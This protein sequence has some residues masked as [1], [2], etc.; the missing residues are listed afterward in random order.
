MP[1]RGYPHERYRDRGFTVVSV[2][3]EF[4][5]TAGLDA[6]VAKDGYEW[7]VLVELDDR[8][9]L[10]QTYNAGDSGGLMVLIDPA[11]GEILARNPS[12]EDIEQTVARYCGDA[13]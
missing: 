9:S 10:W 8:I 11:T 2:A 4:G 12:T 13:E 5:D 1:P 6:A 3:R 7:P